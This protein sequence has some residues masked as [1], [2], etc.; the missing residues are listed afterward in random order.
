MVGGVRFFANPI[1]AANLWK[2]QGVTVAM[3]FLA[4][5]GMIPLSFADFQPDASRQQDVPN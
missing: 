3:I 2:K 4:R 5:E 1:V